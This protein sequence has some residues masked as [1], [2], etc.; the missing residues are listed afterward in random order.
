[1]EIYGVNIIGALL[2]AIGFMAVGFVWYGPLFGK[3]WMALNGFTE[4]SFKDANMAATM[5]KGFANAL[6]TAAILALILTKL[7]AGALTS[8]LLK[9]F[10]LWL[11]FSATTQMLAHIW[12]RQK[13]ELTALN[14]GNQLVGFLVAGAII[15]FFI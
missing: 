7:E 1:M 5:G 8:A 2:G 4:E 14:L 11:G 6:V 12:E 15:S 3:K 10:I 9:S 13:F